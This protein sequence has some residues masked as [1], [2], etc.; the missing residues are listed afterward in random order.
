MVQSGAASAECV[1]DRRKLALDAAGQDVSGD[2]VVE[3][4]TYSCR[5]D[6]GGDNVQVQVELHRLSDLAASIIVEQRSS[7]TIR[8]MM[9]APKLIANDVL[10]TYADLLREFGTNVDRN[11]SPG[12]KIE[13]AGDGGAAA[14]STG[15]KNEVRALSGASF[16]TLLPYPAV[17]EMEALARK[18]IPPGLRY[19][20]SVYCE[21]DETD[22]GTSGSCKTYDRAAVEMKFWR[23]MRAA[24]VADFSSRMTAYNGKHAGQDPNPVALPRE[25]RLARHLAGT[26]WPD[27]F[28]LLVGTTDTDACEAGFHYVARPVTLDIAIIENASDE[29]VVVDDLLGGRS[30]ESGLRAATPPTAPAGNGTPLGMPVG[31]LAPGEKVLVPLRIGL[32]IDE[33]LVDLFKHR[34]TSVQ[35]QKKVGAKGFTGNVAGHGAPNLK[36]YTY[37]P[38]IA[39]TGLT[40]NGTPLDLTRRSV[41]YIE[42]TMSAEEGSCPYLTSEGPDGTWIEHGK[43][44][45]KA[46]RQELAYSD[47]R[48]FGG[49]RSRFRIEERE[50]ELAFI[51]HAELVVTLRNGEVLALAPDDERLARRDGVDV[52]LAW[53]ESLAIDFSLPDA[54][55]DGEVVESR[56]A[57]SGYYRRYAG[58]TAARRMGTLPAMPD[59]GFR[60][61]NA[62]SISLRGASPRRD[63]LPVAERLAHPWRADARMRRAGAPVCRAWPHVMEQRFTNEP[64]AAV[65]FHP[66]TPV[67]RSADTSR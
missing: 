38:E 15:D 41:N 21:D 1:E 33:Y 10:T 18:T 2:N 59:F 3:L 34:Q 5:G 26:N 4:R 9:G 19:F 57:V 56:L 17:D 30:A 37:G 29:P 11:L 49:L 44:L 42:M 40:V 66:V 58:L 55:P 43:V 28:M 65:A 51:D 25:L 47:S 6:A 53:G 52:R 13:A 20:Y 32:G 46:P 31:T 67:T 35:I 36:S 62:T 7:G 27:D 39:L 54:V 64:R 8:R 45:D 14:G 12:F 50:P 16:S 48:S 22:V 61:N 23:P 24:D 60:Q 63:T